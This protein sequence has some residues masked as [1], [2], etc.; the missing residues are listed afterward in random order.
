[1][2]NSDA[3]AIFQK[4]DLVKG[5]EGK[6]KFTKALVNNFELIKKELAFISEY[7]NPSKEFIEFL[8]EKETILKKFSTG[9]TTKDDLVNYKIPPENETEYRAAIEVLLEKYKETIEA[10][11]EQEQKYLEVLKEECTIQFM[12]IA[13]SDIPDKITMEQMEVI[14]HWIKM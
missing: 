6:Y 7:V 12:L 11:K 13:E 2:K 10:T 3:I 8:G 1:M 4:K 9:S 14:F 5:L